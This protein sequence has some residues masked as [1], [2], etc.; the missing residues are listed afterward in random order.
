MLRGLRT[1]Y[2]VV[3]I[4]ILPTIS[5]FSC[6]YNIAAP[7][8]Q[9]SEEGNNFKSCSPEEYRFFGCLTAQWW[10]RVNTVMNLRFL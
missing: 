3:I 7:P 6:P 9:K 2:G 10:A 4:S 5:V 8:P 1:I